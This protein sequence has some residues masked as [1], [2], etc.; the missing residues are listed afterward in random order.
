M[1]IYG[2]AA[3]GNWPMRYIVEPAWRIFV[4]HLPRWLVP[5]ISVLVTTATYPVVQTLY[6]LPRANQLA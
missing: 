5:L 6:V 2:Y 4:C 3:E 1:I